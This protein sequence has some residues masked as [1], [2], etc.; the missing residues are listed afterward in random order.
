MATPEKPKPPRTSNHHYPSK[1][2]EKR[3]ERLPWRGIAPE[4]RKTRY[5]HHWQSKE[6]IAEPEKQTH[7][8]GAQQPIFENKA[9]LRK[10]KGS[11]S[12]KSREK[13]NQS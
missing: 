11:L 13:I 8:Q 1:E 3:K 9:Y 12:E 4:P 2:A 5:K 7:T 6:P 10:E